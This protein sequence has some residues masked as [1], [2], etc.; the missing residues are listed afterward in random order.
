MQGWAFAQLVECLLYTH[1]DLSSDLQCPHKKS[2]VVAHT[3]NPSTLEA[4]AA[5]LG[6]D[7]QSVNCGCIKRDHVLKYK[8]KSVMDEETFV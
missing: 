2:G 6:L 1:E 7:V 5:G 4:E 8:V 3:C